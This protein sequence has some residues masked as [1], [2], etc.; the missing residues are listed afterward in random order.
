MIDDLQLLNRLIARHWLGRLDA[1]QEAY[2]KHTRVCIARLAQ[3]T[4][5]LTLLLDFLKEANPTALQLGELNRR[6]LLFVRE[7]CMEANTEHPD[8]LIRLGITLEQ[9]GWLQK[10]S[11]D[12]IDRLAFGCGAPMIR[13]ATRAFQR[14]VSLHA[15]VGRQHA[16]ALVSAGPPANL[17]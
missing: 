14:G 6:Y 5:E 3:S 4:A 9:A 7:A 2:L 1:D 17:V 12:D 16:A 10:L 13:F 15:H 8:L 11:N